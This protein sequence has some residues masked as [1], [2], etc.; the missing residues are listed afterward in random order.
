MT[1]IYA[2]C[3]QLAR[4]IPSK[5]LRRRAKGICLYKA[6]HPKV[7]RYLNKNYVAP[8][9]KGEL[10]HYELV[11]SKHS[12]IDK[13]SQ[14]FNKTAPTKSFESPKIIWQFWAQGEKNAPSLI[15]SCL[16]S[17][18]KQMNDYEIII[19]DEQNL[20][21]FIN[22]PPFVRE[23]LASGAF[24]AAFF[25]DLLRVSLL[26]SYGGVWLDASIFLSG[27]IPANLL[28]KDFFAFQR[29][30]LPPSDYKLWQGFDYRYFIWADDFA[31]RLF[32]AFLVA[33]PR[34]KIMLALQDILL[35]FW[36]CESSLPHYF[37][38]HIIFDLLMKTPKFSAL[39]CENLGDTAV[40]LVQLHAKEPFDEHLWQEICAKSSIHKLTH[41][42]K[43]PQ[44]FVDGILGLKDTNE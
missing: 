37:T 22:F 14:N 33:K 26:A 36:R 39:N 5:S 6:Q 7:A 40:H 27:K 17:A 16:N 9:L 12:K 41:K 31:V 38:L 11:P 28:K 21:D 18:R 19:L 13:N 25:S 20:S 35:D 3:Y 24:G 15:K 34:H 4:L 43:S 29:S 44:P 2:L 8:F 42:S 1:P 10:K 23:K 32:S 30:T